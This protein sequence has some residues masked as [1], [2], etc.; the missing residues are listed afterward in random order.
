[1]DLEVSIDGL[2]YT[3]RYKGTAPFQRQ[4]V[5]FLMLMAE[6]ALADGCQSLRPG[7]QLNVEGLLASTRATVEGSIFLWPNTSIGQEGRQVLLR[8]LEIP[9]RNATGWA[10]ARAAVGWALLLLL[11]L[12]LGREAWYG[13]RPA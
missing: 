7:D 2:S 1:R 4:D 9:V 10:R 8:R 5:R 11:G 13:L 3:W 6:P 12:L